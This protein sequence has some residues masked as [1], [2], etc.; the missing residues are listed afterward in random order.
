M[1]F[2]MRGK[3][4]KQAISRPILAASEEIEKRAYQ[5]NAAAGSCCN[6]G[7][8]DSFFPEIIELHRCHLSHCI[9]HSRVGAMMGTRTFYR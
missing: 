4:A 8:L 1:G 5:Y 6:R 9:W 2:C 7:N 3:G